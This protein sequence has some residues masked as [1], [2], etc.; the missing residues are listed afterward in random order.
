LHT[1]QPPYNLFER[2]AEKDVLPYCASHQIAVLAYGSLCR[3]L[4]SGRM[5]IGSQFT[6]DDLRRNDPKFKAP[7]F[8]QYLDAVAKLDAFAKQNYSKTVL[9]LAVRYVLDKQ[10]LSIALWGARHPGQ[11]DPVAEVMGWRLD[12][13][14]IAEIDKIV[15]ACVHDPVGPEFMA[16]PARAA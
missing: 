1:A 6:G 2:D 9:D 3:G 10:P 16:P 11:L 14:A 4:L 13:A 15:A 8:Q 7:R 5:K 12:P